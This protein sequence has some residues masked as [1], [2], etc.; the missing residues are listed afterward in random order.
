MTTLGGASGGRHGGLAWTRF[1]TVKAS[2]SDFS[3]ESGVGP[4]HSTGRPNMGDV[5][6]KNDEW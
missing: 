4:S 3:W 2:D 6:V 1:Y 5:E